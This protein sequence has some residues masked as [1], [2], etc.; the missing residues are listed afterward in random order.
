[1]SVTSRSLEDLMAFTTALNAHGFKNI[2]V[3][4]EQKSADGRL[5]TPISTTYERTF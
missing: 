3:G 4:G 2:K 1:M 5:L